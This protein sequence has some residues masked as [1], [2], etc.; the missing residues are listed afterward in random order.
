[1]ENLASTPS[2]FQ[3][4][5]ACADLRITDFQQGP[6]QG[7]CAAAALSAINGCFGPSITLGHQEKGEGA[8]LPLG[9]P[10]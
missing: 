10:N 7:C 1:M 3:S 2:I 6:L 4:N 9:Q 8:A 5:S